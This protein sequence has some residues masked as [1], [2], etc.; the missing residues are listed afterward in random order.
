MIKE[1]PR[2][3]WGGGGDWPR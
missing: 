2:S 3:V 1:I